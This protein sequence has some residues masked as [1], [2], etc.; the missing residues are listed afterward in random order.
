MRRAIAGLASSKQR[1]RYPPA[2]RARLVAL[3]RAHPEH[4][5]VSLAKSLG[6]APQTLSRIAS[7]NGAPLVPVRVVAAPA[8]RSSLVV[9]GP[10]GIVVEGLDL[11]GVVMLIRALS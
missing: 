11:D 7:E 2:L 9:R 8:L 6:M 3:M 4:G 1:R 5:I 10:N